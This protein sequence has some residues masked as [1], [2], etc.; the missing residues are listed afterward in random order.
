MLSLVSRLL[1]VYAIIQSAVD[2]DPARLNA[3]QS[4]T[5]GPLV[6]GAS[7]PTV[8]IESSSLT[9]NPSEPFPSSDS[10][11]SGAPCDGCGGNGPLREISEDYG[12]DESALKT[13]SSL[14][15]R[16]VQRYCDTCVASALSAF[17]EQS[18]EA[19]EEFLPQVCNFIL[20]T[21]QPDPMLKRPPLSTIALGVEEY[22]EHFDNG[23]ND[24]TADD[25]NLEDRDI[26]NAP[27]ED[28]L[29]EEAVPLSPL[30]LH[31]YDC[32]REGLEIATL[33][34][35]VKNP[36]LRTKLAWL[37]EDIM[38]SPNTTAKVSDRASRVL[39]MCRLLSSSHSGEVSEA[40][41]LLGEATGLVDGLVSVAHELGMVKAIYNV[42]RD[43][44]V[45]EAKAR[46][47]HV[48]RQGI[49]R[50]AARAG[51]VRRP[52][53]AIKEPLLGDAETRRLEERIASERPDLAGAYALPLMAAPG[54]CRSLR[55]L[56]LV[57]EETLVLNSA[58]RAPYMVVLEL[59]EGETRNSVVLG[60]EET[61]DHRATKGSAYSWDL[62]DEPEQSWPET[63]LRRRIKYDDVTYKNWQE[64]IEQMDL[65]RSLRGGFGE[66]WGE[67]VDRLRACSP[68]GHLT[69]WRLASFMVKAGDDLRRESVAMQFIKLF[70][71]VWRVEEVDVFLRPY[72]IVCTGPGCGFLENV[73]S[74]RSLDSIKKS[75]KAPTLVQYFEEIF[76]PP[77]VFFRARQNFMRSLVAY[78]I[79]T[80]IFQ[81]KD[82]HNGNILI[83]TH[84]HCIHIDFG[85][86]L[87]ESP[88]GDLKWEK[89]PFKMSEDF[90]DLLDGVGSPLWNEFEE[91]MIE[92]RVLMCVGVLEGLS[93][94]SEYSLSNYCFFPFSMR[95]KT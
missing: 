74:A 11:H 64:Y 31:Y 9:A 15:L 88:G 91:L 94:V 85:Y 56:R 37:L 16:G 54:G 58:S 2:S 51:W 40:T 86:M 25:I 65:M 13:E 70:E 52:G 3:L 60:S 84:G 45:P 49:V 42:S 28:E 43:S 22:K 50:L 77:I 29:E 17:E 78:S 21:A 33:R 23:E 59:I 95:S 36:L 66:L 34:R 39:S 79:L 55:V 71:Q 32:L 4:I 30:V 10:G 27:A 61:R 24:E 35:C 57:P 53:K 12:W 62:N 7:S 87:G 89:S 48:N 46:L 82:R 20:G 26:Q 47:E 68:Y 63:F 18:D 80:Y 8:G 83:D 44:L 14:A 41:A 69:G 1:E 76:R 5:F 19:V 38:I 81:M 73:A 6:D 75:T 92:A 90:C 67:K 93:Y 72:A